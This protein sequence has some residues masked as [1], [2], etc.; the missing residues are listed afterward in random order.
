MGLVA[1]VGRP[2]VGKSTLFNRIIEER[3]AI[4]EGQP[5]VTRDRLYAKAEWAGKHFQIVDTGGIVPRSE[6]VFDKAIREQAMLAIEEA[7]VIVFAVDGRD[8]VTPVDTDIAKI[9]RSSSKPVVLVVNKCD[10]AK[11]DL[12][13]AEFYSLGLGEPFAISALNG[14]STGDFLDAVVADIEDDTDAEDTR[15]K[16]AIVGRPN[17]GKSSLTNALL[18]KDRMVVTPIAGTTRDAIDSVLT[19]YG[20]QIVLIDTAGLRRRSNISE[21]IELYSTMRTA[22]A[23]DRSDVTIVVVDATQGLEAQDKRIISDAEVARKGLIIALNKWDLI[24]KDTKTAD[25]FIRKIKEELPTLD[26]VPII[27]ISA[28]TKQRITKVIEMAKEIQARRCVRIPTHELNEE[29]IAMLERTPPPSVKGR[30]LRINYVTQVKTEPPLFAF[31]LNFPELLPDAYKRFIERQLRKLH[32]FEGVPIS[33]VFR[34]K[35]RD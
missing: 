11:A 30:D 2:N 23:I 25:A 26:Y 18:G 27:T 17:V 31:F 7:D 15:L 10:N 9:L 24:E 29:L 6:D 33:F 22:R 12:N 28:L 13:A 5:G 21:S 4:V 19:Y 1:I 32:D 8:G 34:K 3:H 35:S 16:I 20:E 14:R